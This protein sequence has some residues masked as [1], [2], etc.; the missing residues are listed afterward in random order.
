[1]TASNTRI[2]TRWRTLGIAA[3]A[4]AAVATT[5]FATVAPAE[6][7]VTFGFS[8][9]GPVYGYYPYP[10]YGYYGSYYGYAPSYYSYGYPY[11]Y[12]YPYAYGPSF[13]FSYSH[14]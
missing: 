4:V 10:A 8:V 9:G 14:R 12:G 1:M 7:R 5:G 3:L 11:Y 2:S 13:G 6:A